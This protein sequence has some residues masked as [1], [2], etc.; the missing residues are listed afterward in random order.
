[1]DTF[2]KLSQQLISTAEH[3]YM[4]L[5]SPQWAQEAILCS[6]LFSTLLSQESQER[7]TLT[8]LRMTFPS[9]RPAPI[10]FHYQIKR[11]ILLESHY[12]FFESHYF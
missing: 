9:P 5:I 4:F 8:M 12:F 3:L 10:F 7:R 11:H 1:M 6:N 2:L